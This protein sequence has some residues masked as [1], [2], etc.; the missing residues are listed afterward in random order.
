MSK[1]MGK[2]ESMRR[3]AVIVLAALVAVAA[4][5]PAAWAQAQSGEKPQLVLTLSA[6]KEATVKGPDGKAKTEWQDV[7]T[8]NPGDVIRY[9]I[10]YRNA[11]KS[12]ARDAVIVDPVPKGTTYIPGSAAGEG[13]EIGF[14][15]DGK[16]FQAPPQLKYKVRQP[17]GSEAELQA[18]PDMYTHIR[19]TI[20]K[21]VPPGGTGAVS[22]KVKVR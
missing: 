19:W 14:S 21:P 17:D 13:A 7:K 9:T 1:T 15:L 2:E 18:S 11:G 8:G 10:A 22:F 20:S 3:T 4:A 5:A 12:E 6:Q 16:T